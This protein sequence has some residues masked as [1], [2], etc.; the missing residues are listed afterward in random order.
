[1]ADKLRISAGFGSR[2]R[3]AGDIALRDDLLAKYPEQFITQIISRMNPRSPWLVFGNLF[4]EG[5]DMYTKDKGFEVET[6]TIGAE[7]IRIVEET[8]Y[9]QVSRV[10]DNSQVPDV[11][12]AGVPFD[13]SLDFGILDED[14]QVKL[15]DARTM[16]RVVSRRINN[17][18]H[19]DVT[20]V[21]S[22]QVGDTAPGSL[23]R[24]GSPV[25]WGFGNTKGE[26]SSLPNSLPLG[27]YK[28][29]T[30]VNPTM[31]T[32]YGWQETGSYISDEV[33]MFGIENAMDGSKSMIRTSLPKEALESF[34]TSL[35]GQIMDSVSNFDPETLEIN[36]YKGNSPYPDRPSYAGVRQQLDQA[37]FQYFHPVKASLPSNLNRI[38]SIM[39]QIRQVFPNSDVLVVG[40]G[41]GIKWVKQAIRFAQSTSGVTL[42]RNVPADGKVDIGFAINRY[43]T[44]EGNLYMYDMTDA[45][46]PSGDYDTFTYAGITSSDRSRE[47][48]F[49]PVK[50]S[51]DGR[52]L[53]SFKLY[54]KSGVG[55][56]GNRVNRGFVYNKIRGNTGEL[57]GLNGD[58]L[59]NLN[60][61]SLEDM[62][63][64]PSRY[65]TGSTY[66]GNQHML[67]AENVPYIDVYG[68][69]KLTLER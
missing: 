42:F 28:K 43:I 52:R 22:G 66:D 18:G 37:H 30:F 40:E 23:L 16:L 48:Y 26:G 24:V 7:F 49:I 63:R 64:N 60:D 46:Q 58:Q 11:L 38:E 61:G 54:T 53:K 69:I 45:Y 14:E 34:L 31:I 51:A 39:Q 67:L 17:H 50:T 4:G 20:F 47:L 68:I 44:D 41:A 65:E 29:N 36:G 32:R 8:K 25:H 3:V 33:A 12:T 1:M 21:L 35:D 57:D 10:V 59:M 19:L 2:K 6:S 13:L 62:V 55:P 9:R 5:Q 56:N 15:R 27:A